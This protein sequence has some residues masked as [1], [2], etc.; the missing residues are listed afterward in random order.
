MSLRS[1]RQELLEHQELRG[2]S[3]CRAYASQADAWLA[4]LF[5]A[6]IGSDHDGIALVAVGGYGRG[7]LFPH[8]DLDVVLLHRQ[9][10][11]IAEL[12]E[13]I[14]YPVWDEG[15][16]LD[17]SVR[18]PSEVLAMAREDL[19]VQLGLLDC[20]W[21]AGDAQLA[22]EVGGE[23]RR[24]WT[25]SARRWLPELL[26]QVETRR[27]EHGDLA[28]LLEPNLKE[29]HGGM[30]DLHALEA[31]VMAAP[32][33]ESSVDLAAL[34]PHRSLLADVR[35]ELHRTATKPTDRLV[36]QEQDRIAEALG[37]GDADALMAE[38][39]R[40][41]RAIAWAS[42]QAW[43]R[44]YIWSGQAGLGSSSSRTDAPRRGRFSSWLSPLRRS[45][46][47]SP[48]I[49]AE[50][51]HRPAGATGNPPGS[52]MTSEAPTEVEEGI[53]IVLWREP[54]TASQAGKGWAFAPGEIVLLAEASPETDPSLALRVAAVAA[55]QEMPVSKEA[56][57]TL[58]ALWR[59]PGDPWPPG[60]LD[61]LVRL[62][63]TGR[64]AIDAIEALDQRGILVRLI[65]EW[66][67]VR[68]RPQ[69]NAYHRFTVD[70][71]L[72]E[73]AAGAAG[74]AD[75][76]ERPDLLVLGALLHDIGKGYP[77]DHTE[78]GIEVVGAIAKRM[79]LPGE[80]VGTLV[81]MVRYHLLLPDV[82]TRRD[83]DDP[84]T[85]STVADALTNRSNLELL[86]A[87]TEADSL[88]T[89]PSAWGAWKAGLVDELVMRVRARMEGKES[90][91]EAVG[92]A[93]PEI[94]LALSRV[95]ESPG[96]VVIGAIPRLV[97]VAPDRPGLLATVAGVLALWDLDVR[98]ADVRSSA[99]IAIEEFDVEPAHGREPQVD[100]L[101]AD[102]EAAL[103]GGIDLAARLAERE[104]DYRRGRR[105]TSP[106]PTP[107]QVTVD[108]TASEAATV[109]EVR[110]EDSAGLLYRVT[111]AMSSCDIDV[112]TARV[113]TLGHEVVDA[114]Y[115]RDSKGMKLDEAATRSVDKVLRR[116]LLDRAEAGP[117]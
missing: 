56:L 60:V 113:S 19:R 44:G 91:A 13:R 10:R 53:G 74:L 32:E 57:D 92:P 96:V 24:L 87:L 107:T 72:L 11:P 20:R 29:S 97:V 77:G 108:N 109:L 22:D 18:S 50:Q 73:A 104:R 115:V 4:G 33:L 52:P 40:A 99:G 61:A 114:F 65:P 43:R 3:L 69:R 105:N 17:H 85:I 78:A 110:A 89:G 84:A 2:E 82:A 75:R 47:A 62:L 94:E 59:P 35:V 15:I 103:N 58:E 116:A 42:D 81:D 36:L 55:E 90:H 102:I 39:S 63:M 83:L 68:N 70:R 6:G 79:G 41:G 38:L 64:P 25:T 27:R 71:H 86:G 28:F 16:H 106:H 7:Q 8:S 98:S 31:L 34:A 80:D 112:L 100:A 49:A 88:A 30:R 93:D 9:R 76:V 111:A 46:P 1:D 14:W 45:E 51:S 5:E 67:S 48:V 66:Q 26:S 37:L 12:A 117:A 23:A 95:R 101:S 21:V 54:T